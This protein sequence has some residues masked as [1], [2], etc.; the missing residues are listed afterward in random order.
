MSALEETLAAQMTLAKLPTFKREFCAI[1]GR[2]FRWDFAF[3]EKRLLVECQGGIWAK[4][5]QIGRAH[6]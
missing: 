1:P 3:T 6:V 5:A 2:R 4:G